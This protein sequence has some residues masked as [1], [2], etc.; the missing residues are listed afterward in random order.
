MWL[1]CDSFLEG[2]RRAGWL[3]GFL[4]TSR[5][6]G[7]AVTTSALAVI[8]AKVLWALSPL[9]DTARYDALR[10]IAT[11]RQGQKDIEEASG[12]VTPQCRPAGFQGVST[13][14]QKAAARG[15]LLRATPFAACPARLLAS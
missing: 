1:F 4:I 11:V 5:F 12:A 9:A 3:R 2:A 14:H 15:K 6:S 13:P 7:G 8:P 10:A